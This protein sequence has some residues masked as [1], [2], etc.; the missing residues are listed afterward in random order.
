MAADRPD[1][2]TDNMAKSGRR[3]RIY[4]DYLRNGMGA[5]AVAAYSTRARD[6]A[7]VSVPL[8]W[9]ELGP[10]IRANHFTLLNLPKRLAFLDSDPWEGIGSLKQTLPGAPSIAAPSKAELAA[11]WKKVAKEG[12]VHLARRPLDLVPRTPSGAVPKSV[13]RVRVGNEDRLW[14]DS[15]EGLLALV[16][17]GVVEMHPWNVTVDDLEHPDLLVFSIGSGKS[18]DWK[19]AAEIAVRLRALLQAE[20]LESW[21]KLTGG[22]ELHVMVPI[23][24]ELSWP[25]AH[26]YSEQIAGKLRG[27][28]VDCRYNARGAA[29]IGAWSPRA[30]AGFPIAAPLDWTQLQRGVRPDAF[31]MQQPR[32]AKKRQ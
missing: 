23:E 15:V 30:L 17:V 2:Y 31:T 32:G 19:S 5:T 24:P 11:Y 12:V 6:G 26:R 4:V 20:G 25:E 13:K 16:E 1:L 9:D 8:A 22:P 21:P 10:D 7:P 18:P 29:A 14:V 3:G 27:A 28:A